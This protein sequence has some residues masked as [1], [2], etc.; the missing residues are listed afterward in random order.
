MNAS[1]Q[2]PTEHAEYEIRR[3][4]DA[5]RHWKTPDGASGIA[6]APNLNHIY[7]SLAYP[8][9][10]R[11]L[12]VRKLKSLENV[13]G[14]TV[15]DRIRDERGWAFRD[16]P[17]HSGDPVNNFQFLAEAYK[18]TDSRFDGRVTVPVLWDK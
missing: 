10:S 7:V 15:V 12:I 3:Q 1:P 16:G 17:G 18:A 6:T 2:F 14:L 4:E 8:W 11:T 5:F 9:A 13:I